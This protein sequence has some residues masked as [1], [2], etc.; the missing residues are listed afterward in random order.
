LKVL[1]AGSLGGTVRYPRHCDVVASEKGPAPNSCTAEIAFATPLPC[2]YSR[3][4][5]LRSSLVR[6]PA[7]IPQGAHPALQ[8]EI[9]CLGD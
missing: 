2:A 6:I 7:I 1:T 3:L 8:S 4:R 5:Q 9:S